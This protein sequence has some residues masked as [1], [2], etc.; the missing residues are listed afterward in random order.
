MSLE[1]LEG[2]EAE[3]EAKYESTC[4]DENDP[5][6]LS[7]RRKRC[8]EEDDLCALVDREED[9]TNPAACR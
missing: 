4:G 5:P 6:L 8:L 2:S 9:V 7:T 3:G 1:S